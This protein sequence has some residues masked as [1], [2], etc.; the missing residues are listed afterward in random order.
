MTS[1][2]TS[3]H[4]C[5][6][7]VAFVTGRLAEHSLRRV[8]ERLEAPLSF[9]PRVVVLDIA[10]AALMTTDWLARKLPPALR[11]DHLG[12]EALPDRLVLPG[13][14]R[15]NLE[16]LRTAIGAPV[17][18]G[19]RD[20]RELPAYLGRPAEEE[21]YGEWDIEIIAEINHVPQLSADDVLARA[22]DA[23]ARGADVIDL[24]CDPGGPYAGLAAVVRLLRSHDLR[25]SVDSLDPREIV[26]AVDAGA[27]LV[28]SVNGSNIDVVR[29]LDSDCELVVI[30][31]EPSSLD[32]LRAS[33]ERLAAAGRKFRIDPVIE[34]I[35]FGFAASLARY[36][37]VRELYPDAS[38]MMGIGNLTELTD[39]DSSAINVLLL[40]FCQELDIR[41]VLTT[42]V[43]TWA[44]SSIEECDLARRL[45]HWACCHRTLPKHREPRLHLLRDARVHEHGADVLDRWARE[46]KDRNVR[47]FAEGGEIHVLSNAGR[48]HDRDPFALFAAMRETAGM[49][50]DDPSHAFY[51]G[52]EMAKAVTA[53]TLAKNY[54][55]DEALD[56]GFLTRPE[57]GHANR[58]EEERSP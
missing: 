31:D 17:E 43:I 48:L 21:P 20:L 27:E 5:A 22:L 45:V 53:L 23:R 6:E 3:P 49:D 56:W 35:G 18:L 52:Y 25:V 32:G 16:S 28:L 39:A 54:E 15:G 9:T 38:M 41:S 58:D 47:I 36:V 29:D 33:V 55:Q 40:G 46:I 37:R 34:P 57:R 26:P 50:L 11:Q 44:R 2:D 24:G 10:V 4:E 8:L 19:P 12:S 30:P 14:V 13:F 7:V 1:A 51:L 42:E